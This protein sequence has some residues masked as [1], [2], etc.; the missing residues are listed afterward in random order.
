M[1]SPETLDLDRI[2]RRE[3]GR[4]VATLIRVLG[5]VDLAEDAVADA[6]TVA[7]ERWPTTGIPPNPGGWITTT[8][9]NRAIDRLRRESGRH[10]RHRA[11]ARL[12]E[13]GP[14][15]HD[16]PG[17]ESAQDVGDVTVVS[18]DQLRLIF[19]CCHPALSPDVQVALTLRLL[20]GL[21]TPDIAR[22]FVVPEAT[23]AQRIV[24]AKRKIRDTR[25]PY[26]IPEPAE[27]T[28]RLRPV[29]ATIYL[30]YNAGHSAPSG[31]ELVRTEL[32]DEAIRLARLVHEL[33]PDEPEPAG[34]LALLLLTEARRPA[35]IDDDGSPVRLADQ[36]R[37]TWDRTL[38]RDGHAIVRSLLR[39]NQPGPFQVQAAIAAVHA[40]ATTWDETDWAQIVQLYDLL[41]T[42]RS[43]DVVALNRAVAIG[44]LRGASEALA[45]VEEL[46][47]D[48][49]APFHATRAELLRRLGRD[50]E[51]DSAFERAIE[52]APNEAERD[53]LRRRRVERR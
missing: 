45:I 33:M 28:D 16:R 38:I 41:L 34:L 8:A 7:A 5:D 17:D 43:D 6:F 30:V 12:H 27:L 22:A 37:T 31:S 39:R 29:L 20:C 48:L 21:E 23:M 51:A 32:T 26:R 53:D 47:L 44:E 36:D 9:R 13:S 46:D 42:L 25:M 15:M 11:A 50:D 2:Y 1:E 49:Y 40:D 52:L 24:R 19:L 10:E 3:A 35:R 18:D 14:D 4:C